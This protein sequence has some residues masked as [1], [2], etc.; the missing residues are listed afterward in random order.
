[1]HRAGRVTLCSMGQLPRLQ[2]LMKSNAP[3][4]NKPFNNNDAIFAV[5]LTLLQRATMCRVKDFSLNINCAPTK[6]ATL[7]LGECGV[8]TPKD[9]N[10]QKKMD[11]QSEITDSE[12]KPRR[13]SSVQPVSRGE[14]EAMRRW[15]DA[16]WA[17]LGMVYGLRAEKK[18]ANEED[19]FQCFS[20]TCQKIPHG[21]PDSH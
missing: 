13:L 17:W 7:W 9:P 5:D 18:K 15:P 21:C 12:G 6:S 16:R 2:R 20:P 11:R 3:L 14:R 19:R 4:P 8:T 1:M 10:T